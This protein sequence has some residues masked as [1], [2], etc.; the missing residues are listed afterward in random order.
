MSTKDR[1]RLFGFE[2][3][4]Q[5]SLRK[6]ED[7]QAGIT[8]EGVRRKEADFCRKMGIGPEQMDELFG[9]PDYPRIFKLVDTRKAANVAEARR[10][11][12]QEEA[13]KDDGVQVKVDEWRS[14]LGKKWRFDE[15]VR[16]DVNYERS[17]RGRPRKSKSDVIVAFEEWKRQ[18]EWEVRD[19]QEQQAA[20]DEFI[21]EWQASQK[22]MPDDV[23]FPFD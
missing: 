23:S 10:L 19:T 21:R 14:K 18:K 15:V 20:W 17:Q 1:L 7:V 13:G 6:A 12:A 5:A 8:Q 16:D 3:Q 22:L 11:I 2:V 4:W 9:D